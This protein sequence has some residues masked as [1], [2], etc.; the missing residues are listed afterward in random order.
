MMQGSFI[1]DSA[2]VCGLFGN[3]SE[4]F[5]PGCLKFVLILNNQKLEFPS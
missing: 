1:Y 4:S 5:W 3:V 2:G